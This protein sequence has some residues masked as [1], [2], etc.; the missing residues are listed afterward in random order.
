VFKIYVISVVSFFV[1][2][3]STIY[4]DESKTWEN[5]YQNTLNISD[6]HRT[7]LLSQKYFQLENKMGGVAADLGAGTGR[8]TL[9]LLRQGWNVLAID[10]EQLAIDIILH[11]A[12]PSFSNCLNVMTGQFS[13]MVL[14]NELDLINASYSLPFCNPQDFPKC[15]KMITDQL[16]IGG[17][18]SG[19]FFGE[20]DEWANNP[21]LTIHS[22]ENMLKLFEDQFVIEYLQIEDGLIPS[23]NGKMKH[24]HVYHVVAKKVR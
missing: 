8:D 10:A 3:S 23:A 5:Y 21:D 4:A 11:R 16:S 1:I 24:W 6:P 18:F 19:Q 17:R 14:P 2:F 15:W 12:D 7:L 20:K 13:E 9:F 22:Y